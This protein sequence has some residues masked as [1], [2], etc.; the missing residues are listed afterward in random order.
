MSN[1]IGQAGEYLV[2]AE[3]CRR[4]VIATT[5]SRNMPGFDILA[6]NVPTKKK[7]RIQVKTKS[8]GDWQLNAGK[9]LT[10]DQKSLKKGIQ[11]V[12]GF[13]KDDV[14]DYFVFVELANENGGDIFFI[15]TSKQVKEIVR[16]NY[17]NLRKRKSMHA[18]IS[19]KDLNAYKNNWLVFK[20]G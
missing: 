12:L 9:F 6:L 16:K 4:G 1:S 19:N 8:K 15:L 18:K 11:K 17:G 7:Y 14:A 20:N 13:T 10:F 5:F 2:A 3:L